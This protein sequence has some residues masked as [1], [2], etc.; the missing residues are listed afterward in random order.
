MTE[1]E[2]VL[3][4]AAEIDLEQIGDHIF[5]QSRSSRI[6]FDYIVRLRDACRRIGRLPHGARARPDLGPDLRSRSYRGAATIVYR[7]EP[8]RVLI[9]RILRAGRD[10]EG[11]FGR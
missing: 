4:P 10:V 1:L 3:S 11:A 8:E 2:V 9:L 5:E 6:M 7:V